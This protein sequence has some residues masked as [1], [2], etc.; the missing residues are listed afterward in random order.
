MGSREPP[1]AAGGEPRLRRA[2]GR[3]TT[4]A[5][6][7]RVTLVTKVGPRAMNAGPVAP[8]VVAPGALATLPVP[9]AA[10]PSRLSDPSRRHTNRRGPT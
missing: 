8:R 2:T 10:L 9:T 7:R 3:W 5:A 1:L 6:R 4:A